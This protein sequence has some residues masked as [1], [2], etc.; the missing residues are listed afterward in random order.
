MSLWNIKPYVNMNLLCSNDE[1][2]SC[3]SKLYLSIEIWRI[4]CLISE[5][6]EDSLTTNLFRQFVWNQQNKKYP[7]VSAT[8]TASI[9]GWDKDVN[10]I[11]RTFRGF[12]F[13]MTFC[14]ILLYLNQY[15]RTG[16]EENQRFDIS[17]NTFPIPPLVYNIPRN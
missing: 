9:L 17:K 6:N 3:N 14:L 1:P 5:W 7:S 13:Y 8:S 11:P 10:K 4:W 12:L 15:W 2:P 16:K